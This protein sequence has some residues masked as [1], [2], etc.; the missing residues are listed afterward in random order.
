VEEAAAVLRKQ[1]RIRVQGGGVSCPAP[2]ESFADVRARFGAGRTLMQRLT[3]A[4]FSDPTPIQRQAVPILLGGHELLAVAPT[5]G[6]DR[7]TRGTRDYY[8]IA[9]AR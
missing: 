7:M 8:S 9:T 1:H 5:V 3:E 2:L 4:G 6:R